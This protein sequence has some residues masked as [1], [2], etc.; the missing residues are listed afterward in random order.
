[1]LVTSNPSSSYITR[2]A[3]VFADNGSHV[4]GDLAAVVRAILLDAEA[5]RQ[6]AVNNGAGHLIHPALLITNLLRAFDAKSADGASLSDGYL[7]PQSQT[8]GM[9]IFKPPSVFSYFSPFTGAPGTTL[10]GPEFEIG[11]A[12]CRERG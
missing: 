2:V 4:R 8:M 5:R 3:N 9:D 12:S 6:R 11:R 10:R 1:H 7:N